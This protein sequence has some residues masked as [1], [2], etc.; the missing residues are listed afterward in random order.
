ME[1]G[2]VWDLCQWSSR[3]PL[4]ASPQLPS[5]QGAI[6]YSNSAKSVVIA[7]AGSDAA[8]LILGVKASAEYGARARRAGEPWVH[9]LLQ[10]EIENP[11]ALADLQSARFHMEA[12][13]LSASKTETP[14]YTPDL[15][16]AQFQVFFS[17][18]N[19]NRRSPGYGQYL[20]FGVPIYDDRHRVAPSH[21]AQDTGGTRMFIFTPSGSV[22]TSLSAHDRQWIVIDKELLPLMR[23]GLETAWANGFL[24]DSQSLAD[25]RIAGMNLGWELPGSF[26]VEMQTRNLSLKATPA[27]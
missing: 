11:P 18:Q 21:K 19:L 14:D 8:D 20:W 4:A 16:A 23:E 13:L 3:W 1:T 12:R 24:K 9:L 15:H 10:Q 2:P 6:A 22:F 17:V 7:R 26:D 25:Y 27:K 5:A